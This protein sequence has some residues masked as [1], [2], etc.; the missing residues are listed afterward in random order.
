MN[1]CE[2]MYSKMMGAGGVTS[3]TLLLLGLVARTLGIE[4]FDRVLS[5]GLGLLLFLPILGLFS[6]AIGYWLSRER[7]VALAATALLAILIAGTCLLY[8]TK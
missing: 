5:F 4:R 6:L 8:F 2:Q 3:C 7:L 1:R